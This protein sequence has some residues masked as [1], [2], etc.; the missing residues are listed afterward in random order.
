MK[1]IYKID[2]S[3]SCNNKNVVE[4]DKYRFTVL[5]P[6]MI[7]LEYN[8]NG[9]FEN[10]PT[11]KVINRNFEVQDFKVIDEDDN[12]EII[13]DCIH[14][15]YDKKKFSQNGLTIMVRGNISNYHSIWH[16]SE[17]IKDL[18]GTA[19]TLDGANGAIP[20]ERGL[21]SKDG[22]S[23]ID[24][25]ESLILKEDGWIETR[26]KNITDIYFLGYGRDYL[27]CL[28]DFFKLCGNTP[29]LPKY[30]LGNWWSRYHK[31]TEDEYKE[32][33]ER[34]K[35][36][37]IPFSVAV[38][39]MDWH[40]VDIDPK[41]GSGWS[42][43]TWNKEL[44][45]DP[46]EFM[47]WLHENGLRVTLNVHPADG[48]RA[49]EEMYIEMAKYLDIDYLSEKNIKFDISDP[50]FLEAYFKYAHHPNEEN[51]VDFWWI[52]WQQGNNSKIE[53]L[54]P[55]WM[56]NHYHFL[57]NK[58]S[59]KRPLTF[60]RYAGIGSHRYP[61]GFSGD[62]IITWESLDFQPYFT[63]NASNAGYGW[64]SHDI[65]GHMLGIKDDEMALRWL[66]FGVFSPIMRLHSSSSVFN[67]KEPWRYNSIVHETMNE[68]LRFRHSLIPY[69]YTMNRI[70]SED[71]IPLI[72]PMYY[73]NP[74]N[75]EAYEVPNQYYF[76]SEL[77][78]CP[79]THPINKKIGRG[80]VKVWL[81]D[82]IYIDIFN[83]MIYS[84]NRNINLYRDIKKIPVLA[85]AGAI[86]PMIDMK[87][88]YN[89]ID[90]PK[91]IEIRIFAGNNGTFTMYEDDGQSL[92]YLK[93]KYAETEMSLEWGESIIR[94]IIKPIKGE[95][96]IVPK[97]RNYVLKYIGFN[98]CEEITVTSN[99]KEAAYEKE[100]NNL[101][102]M[103]VIKSNEINSLEGLVVEFKGKS[104][105]SCNNITKHIF[106]FLNE[107][108]IEFEIKDKIYNIINSH[109][110]S[111]KI[112]GALQTL[113]L[114]KDLFGAICEIILAY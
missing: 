1:E 58:R 114:D 22:F 49:H 56:L 73:H 46:K 97:E 2:T 32:L 44:F 63:A 111:V 33:I 90:N 41:Y 71:G 101:M 36:E 15:I 40:L 34:F 55:L 30:A 60:S 16:Y 109:E 25:S 29:F 28:K 23:I 70:F 74:E 93:G 105:L 87:N 96:S 75:N 64:W 99:N 103:I 98:D 110:T 112:I 27:K 20:L 48:I 8:D 65:G 14:L 31:Y 39:D 86:I 38:I 68:F 53:G 91:D 92:E 113:E 66:Q 47:E 108:Q 54:D 107:A 84:G 72:Q 100:Y 81:P 43:Y 12:L 5:T 26:E 50:K 88:C 7:R 83:G 102:N 19:R 82:G 37:K 77:I 51:G 104:Q 13:T 42:G 52:D 17:E 24:D 94:F 9:L 21:I 95:S 67:G 4:G 69:I 18:K 35:R 45:P 6:Q 78:A 62:S 3:P 61:V 85:K 57:D 80:K 76:G 89:Q 11:Q 79:I 59:G 10:R 106:D